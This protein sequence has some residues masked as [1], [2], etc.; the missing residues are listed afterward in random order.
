MI[1]IKIL[2]F[3]CHWNKIHP[4]ISKFPDPGPS[5]LLLIQSN[6]VSNWNQNKQEQYFVCNILTFMLTV[7][8]DKSV[9]ILTVRLSMN[10]SQQPF[11]H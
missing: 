5:H 1:V 6:A 10:V 11:S 8:S 9:V 3:L 2:K 7:Y 4:S